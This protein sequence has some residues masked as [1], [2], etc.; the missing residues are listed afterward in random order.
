MNQ[1]YDDGEPLKPTR[2]LEELFTELVNVGYALG[3]Q[4]QDELNPDDDLTQLRLSDWLDETAALCSVLE[5][6]REATI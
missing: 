5:M 1:E 2:T 6:R 4:W 3:V